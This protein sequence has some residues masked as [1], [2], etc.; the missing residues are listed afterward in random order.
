MYPQVPAEDA[1]ELVVELVKREGSVQRAGY[2]FAKRHGYALVSGPRILTRILH[3]SS[4]V[5][6]DVYDRLWVML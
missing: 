6:R 3:E 5:A 4:W 1:R 2:A